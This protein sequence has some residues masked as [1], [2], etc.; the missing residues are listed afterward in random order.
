MK[1]EKLLAKRIS[2]YL[3]TTYPN[4]I[5]R[6]DL[7]A[8]MK[9]SIGQATRNKELHG[10]FNRGYPDL[11]I[12]KCMNGF[13]GLYVELKATNKLT[14]S[15]HTDEQSIIHQQL[16]LSG[17]KVAFTFGYDDTKRVID[18]YLAP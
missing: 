9:L 4:T 18:E 1:P 7:S 11:F 3:Q 5:F 2:N 16:T 15:K 10:I 13:G 12:A 17:Y 8:D 14:K 6:F